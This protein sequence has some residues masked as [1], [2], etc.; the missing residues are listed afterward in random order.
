M[1]RRG[2]KAASRQARQR[3]RERSGQTRPPTIPPTESAAPTQPPVASL[4][5]SAAPAARSATAQRARPDPRL[6]LTG[7]SRL[8][9]RARQEYHY[10]GRDLRNIGVLVALMG[11]ILLVAFVILSATGLGRG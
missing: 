8:G 9:D 4:S 7:P 6:S 11:A 10:V 5:T 3:R 1:A 2:G